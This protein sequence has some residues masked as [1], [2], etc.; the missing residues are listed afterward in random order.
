MKKAVAVIIIM[1]IF[2]G[3]GFSLWHNNANYLKKESRSKVTPTII[4]QQNENPSKT[5]LTYCNSAQLSARMISEGAAGNIY[6][7]LILKNISQESCQINGDNL[8]EIGYPLSVKNFKTVAKKEPTIKKFDLKPNQEIYSLL[9]YPNGP[10]CSSEATQV[11][12]MVSYQIAK[13]A[14]LTFKPASGTTLLIPSCEKEN[15][16]TAIDLYPFSTEKITP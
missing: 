8:P 10:Q 2:L 3:A 16:Q 7:T 14:S 6:V 5:T 12:S 1:I 13:D 11:N 9:H 4:Q 15:E